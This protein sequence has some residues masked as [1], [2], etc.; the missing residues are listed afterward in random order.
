VKQGYTVG[1]DTS[2]PDAFWAA[3]ETGA[4]LFQRCSRRVA[5]GLVVHREGWF[6]AHLVTCDPH[7]EVILERQLGGMRLVW[8]KKGSRPGVAPA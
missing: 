7:A 3:R 8:D 6:V 2:A 5:R 1:P 4:C